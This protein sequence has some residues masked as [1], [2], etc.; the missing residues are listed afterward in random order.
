LLERRPSDA[1][2][3][4]LP[5]VC[6]VCG[7]AVVRV[8]DE[9]VARCTGGRTVCAAQRKEWIKHF[10]SR[11]AMDVEGL[12]DKLIE[13]LVDR[14]D[15][16]TPADLYALDAV[17][18][19]TLERMGERSASKVIAAIEDSRK[20]TLPRVLF[21]LGIPDVGESTA[22][23][24]AEQFG[25]IEALMAASEAEIQQTP[26][27]GPVVARELAQFFAAP[28]NRELVSALRERGVNWSDMPRRAADLPLAGLTLVLTGTLA[29]TKRDEAEDALRS[30]GAKVSGSVSKKT[31]FVIAGADAGS[32]LA[33][34][35]ELGIR[36]LDEDALRQI[37][38][39]KRPPG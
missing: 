28:A 6:P 1:R 34:A 10:A 7:S 24:L 29:N 9:A 26:D 8:A 18:L 17:A 20:T 36:V 32:K 21:A 11:R 38:E 39:T 22:L 23:A 33:K 16:K 25:S 27:V 37:L 2:L 3:I 14:G 12:G 35:Q 30:L 4:E 13:Q 15:V 19:A 31:S 5:K